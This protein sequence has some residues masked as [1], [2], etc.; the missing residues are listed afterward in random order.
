LQHESF[1]MTTLVAHKPRL[2]QY[3][4]TKIY[5]IEEYLNRESAA[6]SK[7]EFYNGQIIAMLGGNIKHNMIAGNIFSTIKVAIKL[8]KKDFLTL[9][10]DQK[11]FIP[12]EEIA[13]YPDALV[14]AEKPEYWNNHK[15]LITNPLLIVEVLS[16]STRAYDRGEKFIHYRTIPSFKE[17]VLIEQDTKSIEIW[18]KT[19]E[20]T[21][22]I[23]NIM[24]EDA[25]VLL[26]SIG[27]N[28]SISDIYENTDTL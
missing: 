17:Y 20:N 4:A 3:R 2:A 8:A 18:Y 28:I 7:S 10:S 9:N 11:I 19:E 12:N 23:T 15:D 27:L 16:K 26:Q 21:W 24:G 5:S 13:V 22:K 25:D 6:L 14:I 1:I